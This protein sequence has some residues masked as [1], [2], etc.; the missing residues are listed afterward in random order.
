MSEEVFNRKSAD[1]LT[2]RIAARLGARQEKIERMAE[3]ERPAFIIKWRPLVLPAMAVAACLIVALVVIAPRHSM[4]VSSPDELDISAPDFEDYRAAMPELTEITQL[5]AAG[6][7]SEALPKVEAALQQSDSEL[8]EKERAL[9]E[10]DD[11]GLAYEVETSQ[12]LNG[13]LRWAYIY[14]LVR[15]N[16]IRSAHAELERYLALP[17]G[18]ISHQEEAKDLRMYL[19][20]DNN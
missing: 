16:N 12:V 11:E 13:E 1:E 15:N 2:L 17:S 19:R 14:L 20:I 6:S 3:W 8:S 18:T 7:Y 9:S 5:I 10:N 4:G